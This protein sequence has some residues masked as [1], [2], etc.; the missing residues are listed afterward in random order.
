[1]ACQHVRNGF[2]TYSVADRAPALAIKLPELL[3]K[4]QRDELL[5]QACDRL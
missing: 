1:M 3:L 4:A 5:V 2:V